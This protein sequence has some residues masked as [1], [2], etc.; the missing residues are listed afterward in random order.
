MALRYKQTPDDSRVFLELVS[1]E[2]KIL[3]QVLGGGGGVRSTPKGFAS[4]SH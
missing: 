3:R 1:E 2:Q 4:L